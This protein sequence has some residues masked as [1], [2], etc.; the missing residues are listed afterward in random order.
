MKT[1]LWK[2]GAPVLLLA[3]AL[4]AGCAAP[5]VFQQ[6]KEQKAQRVRLVV[7]SNPF[8]YAPPASGEAVGGGVPGVM[9]FT[10]LVAVAIQGQLDSVNTALATAANTQGVHTDHRQAFTDEVVRQFKA[11][12]VEV[13]LVPLPYAIHSLGGDRA[14][15]KPEDKDLAALPKDAPAFWLRTDFGS[16]TIKVIVPCVRYVMQPVNAAAAA[17]AN[18]PRYRGAAGTRAGKKEEGT[19]VFE[20]LDAAT[21]HIQDFDAQFP[22]LIPRAVSSLAVALE[23]ENRR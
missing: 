10:A 4:L 12:G 23:G 19:V 18:A 5:P 20:S 9:L 3:S 15:A 21:T 22:A 8:A 13:E 11:R 2:S 1:S 17:G 14:W 7:E 16:C 6:L